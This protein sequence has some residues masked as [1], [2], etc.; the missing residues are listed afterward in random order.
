MS[1]V[2]PTASPP[3]YDA[4]VLPELL[5]TDYP[6]DELQ[7]QVIGEFLKSLPGALQ[8]IER[9][10]LDNDVPA[11]RMQ[12]HTLKATSATV[13]A[14]EI[15]EIT[16]RQDALLTAGGAA[17]DQLGA[18]LAAMFSRFEAALALHRV[19]VNL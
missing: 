3:A 18:Q 2:K 19:K 5:G 6:N 1:L 8:A 9:A 4:T 16:Y 13:G 7:R 15:A 12:M 10:L 11:L 14:M 17:I